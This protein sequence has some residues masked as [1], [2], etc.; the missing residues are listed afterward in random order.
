MRIWPAGLMLLLVGALAAT[1]GLVAKGQGPAGQERLEPL[2]V[3]RKDGRPR[4][5]AAPSWAWMMRPRELRL[6]EGFGQAGDGGVMTGY[7]HADAEGGG[8]RVF[9]VQ[10]GRPARG[11]SCPT[12][13]WS[14]TMAAA[15]ATSPADPGTSWPT[16]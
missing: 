3:A 4:Y 16:G 2:G 6:G 15:N 9:L 11:S 5:A 7:A 8:L 13:A 1:G 12:I 10:A 14:S